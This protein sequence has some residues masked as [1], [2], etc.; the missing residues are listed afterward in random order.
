MKNRFRLISVLL[1]LSWAHFS[2]ASFEITEIMYD[3]DGTDTGREWVEVHNIGTASSDLSKWYLFSDNT[4]HALAP[5][6]ASNVEAGSYAVITQDAAKFKI[7]WP[8]Y[9]GLLFDSSWTGFNND[10][11]TIALKDPDQN[12]VSSVTFTSSQGGA[13]NG[14]SLQ[15]TSSS[16]V[17]ATPTPGAENQASS[18]SGGG[19]GTGGGGGPASTPTEPKPVIKKEI[20][21]P[22][23]TTDIIVKNVIFSNLPFKIN[24]HTLGLSKELLTTGKFVWNFGDGKSI[25]MSEQKEFSYSYDYTGEYVL[26]LSYYR[27]Y[28]SDTPEATDRVLIKV[29]PSGVSISSVG[30]G[31]DAYVELENKSTYEIDI[32]LWGIKGSVHYFTIP[33]GTILLPKNKLKFSPRVTGFDGGDVKSIILQN[34]AGETFAG[35]PSF[36]KTITQGTSK[37]ISKAEVVDNSRLDTSSVIDLDNLGASALDSKPGVSGSLLSFAGLLGII[38][39]GIITIIV[40]RKRNHGDNFE[41][42]LKASDIT[43]VE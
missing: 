41:S 35:F 9:S 20:E 15:K 32:S 18:G 43:I 3:L 36:S 24:A 4:K 2:H 13:G 14:H 6:G 34:Q 25:T 1:F 23:V 21:V 8:N 30:S 28:Y 42:N 27:N 31:T 22:R 11:E 7:D 10:G 26:S 5:Q 38:A 16:W 12:I 40:I 37:S 19:G 17:G 33:N 39:I 29:V